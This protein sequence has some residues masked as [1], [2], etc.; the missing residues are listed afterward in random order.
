MQ[1]IEYYEYVPKPHSMIIG[2]HYTTLLEKPFVV[3]INN[4]ITL[5][6]KPLPAS[7]LKRSH[8]TIRALTNQR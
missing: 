6:G 3:D 4:E 8:R 2:K 7:L 5:M 1:E